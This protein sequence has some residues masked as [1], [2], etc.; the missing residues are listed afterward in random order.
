MS[1]ALLTIHCQIK[2]VFPP[3]LLLFSLPM[4][5]FRSISAV[6]PIGLFRFRPPTSPP[7][8]RSTIPFCVDAASTLRSCFGQSFGQLRRHHSKHKHWPKN[9]RI[10]KKI[11]IC[12]FSPAIQKPI[13]TVHDR[14]FPVSSL[15]FPAFWVS[16]RN[17]PI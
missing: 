14:T 3:L 13:S 12:G 2:R 7:V 5:F 4:M 16:N 11:G 15:Q 6:L 10:Y 17:R 1:N 8:P 9:L